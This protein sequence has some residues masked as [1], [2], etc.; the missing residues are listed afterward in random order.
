MLDQPPD[1]ASLPHTAE[2]RPPRL[3]VLNPVRAPA[4]S[5]TLLLGVAAS[6]RRRRQV[7]R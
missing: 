4:R 7:R 6:A 3:E 5:S 2:T 1:I